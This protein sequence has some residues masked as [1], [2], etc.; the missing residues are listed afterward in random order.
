VAIVLR[1]CCCDSGGG[2]GGIVGGVCTVVTAVLVHD[3]DGGVGM[4]VW[5]WC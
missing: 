1:S 3:G 5:R 2:S 4:V